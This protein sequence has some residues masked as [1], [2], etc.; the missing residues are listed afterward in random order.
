MNTAQQRIEAHLENLREGDDW[1]FMC[2]TTPAD[3]GGRYYLTPT[4]CFNQVISYTP[5]MCF[6]FTNLFLFQGRWGVYGIWDLHDDSCS[7]FHNVTGQ[8]TRD[9]APTAVE[10]WIQDYDTLSFGHF[11]GYFFSGLWGRT[12]HYLGCLFWLINSV[13]MEEWRVW[14]IGWLSISVKFWSMYYYFVTPT[15]EAGVCTCTA[16]WSLFYL[17]KII[18]HR[19]LYLY[20]YNVTNPLPRPPSPSKYISA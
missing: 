19:I 13:I 4:E 5:L 2:V 16:F 7:V 14:I 9:E 17:L 8:T 18:V 6:L 20:L 10:S 3:I 12:I 15:S 11:S 1:Q